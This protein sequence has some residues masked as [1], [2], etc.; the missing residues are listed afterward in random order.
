MQS[1]TI[2]PILGMKSNV[3]ANDPSLIRPITEGVVAAHCVDCSNVS[4]SDPRHATSKGPGKTQW[5]NSATTSTTTCLGMFESYDGTNRAHWLFMGDGSSNGRVFRYD[6]SRDPARVHD[7]VG[8]GTEYASGVLDKYSVINFGSYMVFSDWGES[9]PYCSDYND[10]NLSKLISS[11][12][13]YKGRYLETFQRRI[14]MANI[15]SGV[16]NGDISVI[17]SGTNPTPSSSCTFGSGDPPTNHLFR[18]LEDP[19]TGIKR[20]GRNSC[21]LYGTNSIDSIDYYANYT[22]P[23]GIR[24]LVPNH[25]SVNHH[26]IVSTG[27]AHYFFDENYGFCGFAGGEFPLGGRPISDDIENVVSSIARTYYG[28][29]VGA[30]IPHKQS[31]YWTVPLYGNTTPDNV[32]KYHLVDKTWSIT[33]IVT[34]YIDNWITDT[35]VTWTDLLAQGFTTWDEIQ[36]MRWSDIVSENPYIMFSNTDGQTYSHSGTSD[37]DANYDGNRVEPILDFGRPNDK[38][39]LLE[40]WFNFEQRGNFNIYVSYR[41]GN[42]LAETT[43]AEWTSLTEVSCND[44]ANA[45]TRLAKVNRFHQIKYGTDSANEDFSVNSIEFRFVPQG[46]Y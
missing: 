19:I 23:F 2:L 43:A 24:N 3:P 34:W 9:T 10:A 30:F 5:S 38:E 35:N 25:G 31:I 46:R 40:I 39:L 8:G 18:S 42:T 37:V 17:W 15:T 22:T 12:T 27:N 26:G 29:I 45:V 11:G 36:G 21:F 1:Y 6:G 14:L 28:H 41:G 4:F 44:P 20:F 13:E 7:G 16:T 32:L 33:P